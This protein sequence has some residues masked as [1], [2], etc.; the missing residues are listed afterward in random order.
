MASVRPALARRYAEALY[1][2]LDS[3]E[4]RQ[5]TLDL[6]RRIAGLWHAERDLRVFMAAPY[7]KAGHRVEA[8]GK[9]LGVPLAHPLDYVL[10]MLLERRRQ[11]MLGMLPEAFE[12]VFDERQGMRR[13]IVTSPLA[14]DD[15][16]RARV[17]ALA[18]RIAGGPVRLEEQV[19]ASMLG[20]LRLRVGDQLLDLSLRSQLARLVE[21]LAATPLPAPPAVR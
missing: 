15:D 1:D 7:L 12:E 17:K 8:L 3:D 18:E 6:L 16:T 21:R 2:S 5:Q 20:G 19:D 11:D 10:E 13:A 14:L 9:I 4:A